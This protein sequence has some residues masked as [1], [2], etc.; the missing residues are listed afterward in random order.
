MGQRASVEEQYQLLLKMLEQ[1]LNLEPKG[2]I[3]HWFECWK[4]QVFSQ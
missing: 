1:E 2:E 4:Q 3:T